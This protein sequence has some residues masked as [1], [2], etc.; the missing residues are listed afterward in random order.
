MRSPAVSESWTYRE[1]TLSVSRA[2]IGLDPLQLANRKRLTQI[3]VC[4]CFTLEQIN[5]TLLPAPCTSIKLLSNKWSNTM[6]MNCSRVFYCQNRL[7][8]VAVAATTIIREIHEPKH[9]CCKLFIWSFTMRQ[10]VYKICAWSN[11]CLN[12]RP[13]FLGVQFDVVD[14]FGTLLRFAWFGV[15]N[16]VDSLLV[17]ISTDIYNCKVSSIDFWICEWELDYLL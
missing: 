6:P 13:A 10:T 9:S 16:V 14:V 8:H 7:R 17:E 15:C 3:F 11:I 12:Y 4:N 1:P 2:G 5:F